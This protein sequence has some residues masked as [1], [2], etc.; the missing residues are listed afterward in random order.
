MPEVIGT[1]ELVSG[2][3]FCRID[4]VAQAVDFLPRFGSELPL[5]GVGSL[6]ELALGLEQR[7]PEHQLKVRDLVVSLVRDAH[8][9]AVV[10]KF[11]HPAA[12]SGSGDHHIVGPQGRDGA[13]DRRGWG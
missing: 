6:P 3:A 5:E 2:I 11:D 12:K 7:T 4:V 13:H 10:E 9:C 1:P 8:G